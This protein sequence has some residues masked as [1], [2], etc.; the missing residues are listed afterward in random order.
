MNSVYTLV[1]LAPH[2]AEL[3][4]ILLTHSL[5]LAFLGRAGQQLADGG[6]GSGS[7]VGL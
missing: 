4:I 1:I 3:P 7:D 5:L 2:D 6:D